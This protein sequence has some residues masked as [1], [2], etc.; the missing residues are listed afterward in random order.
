M[1]VVDE[2]GRLHAPVALSPES[3]VTHWTRPAGVA[4]MK[5]RNIYS[6]RRGKNPGRP[7]AAVPTEPSLPDVT[8]AMGRLAIL[9]LHM[10][11]R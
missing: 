9:Y 3:P 5:H 1:S 2:C 4:A 10:Q 11:R 8:C 7:L 6:H